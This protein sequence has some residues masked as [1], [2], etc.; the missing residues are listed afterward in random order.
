MHLWMCVSCRR[1]ERQMSL[2]RRALR[3]LGKRAELADD[4]TDFPPEARERIR[5]ALAE[6]NEHKHWI[7]PVLRDH[8]HEPPIRANH[9]TLGE[10]T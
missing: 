1:F 4:S 9:I 6:R 2:M 5:K 10:P 8:R 3:L 7:R